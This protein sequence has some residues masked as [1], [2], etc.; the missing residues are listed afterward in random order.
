MPY[1]PTDTITHSKILSFI[2]PYRY[3]LIH[4]QGLEDDSDP[5]RRGSTVHAANEFYVA[6]LVKAGATS[7]YDLAKVALHDAIVEEHCPAHL[8]PD[9]QFLWSNHVERFELDLEAFLEAEK[10]TVVGELSFKPDYVLAKFDALEI[11]DLKTM[12]QALDEEGAK[13]DLQ[14]RMYALLASKVWPGFPV[15]KFIFHF[16]RLRHDVTATFE[17]AELDL[18]EEQLGALVDAIKRAKDEGVYPASPGQQCQYCT[19]VCPRVDDARRMPARILTNDFAEQVAG[20][21]LVCKT[22]ATQYQRVLEEYTKQFGP[23]VAA[24]YEWAHRPVE[25]LKFPA[26]VV[27]DILHRFGAPLEKLTF[28]KTAV[29]SYLTAKKW[30]HIKPELEAIQVATTT[31]SFRGKKVNLMGEDPEENTYDAE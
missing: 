12:F 4:N 26:S 27:L 25:R 19:F 20:D 17:P 9:V 18:I 1:K 28:G 16:V 30:A 13:K 10:R 21:L 5:A 14:A 24:Q 8:L 22:A 11:H 2:C 31:T 7:D 15:Y 6:A 23:V 29:K 3:D